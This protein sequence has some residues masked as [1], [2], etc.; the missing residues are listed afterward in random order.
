MHPASRITKRAVQEEILFEVSVRPQQLWVHILKAKQ[1]S[2]ALWSGRQ[3]RVSDRAD[4]RKLRVSWGSIR[5]V[6]MERSQV[7]VERR[8]V[9]RKWEG[10]IE[11]Q[12]G[13]R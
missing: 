10:S 7:K 3:G 4:K 9:W 1:V 2:S 11:Y 5:T 8:G 6:H 12:R 13:I